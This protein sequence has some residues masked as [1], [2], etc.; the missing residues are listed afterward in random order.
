[1]IVS[2]VAVATRDQVCRRVSSARRRKCDLVFQTNLANRH[3]PLCL[4]SEKEEN[5]GKRAEIKKG[6]EDYGERLREN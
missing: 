3:E 6:T 1:M 2:L 5:A 4:P